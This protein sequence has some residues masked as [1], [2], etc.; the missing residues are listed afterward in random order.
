MRELS[1]DEQQQLQES[2]LSCL[3]SE[4]AVIKVSAPAVRDYLQGQITQ[5]TA[6]LTD[7]RG[8]YAAVLTPQGKAVSDIHLIQGH[9][10][11]LIIIARKAKAV[12]LVGRLRQFSL[13]HELRCGIVGALQLVSVQGAGAESFL[14]AGGLPVPG[15]E[16][17]ATVAVEGRECF[18]MRMAE[19]AA[20]GFWVVTDTANELPG[21][22]RVDES[23]IVTSRIIKGIPAFGIDWNEQVLPLNANLI[24]FDGV[25][26]NKGCYIGQEVTS[27]MQWRGGIKKHLYR[28]MLQS[29]P[30]DLPAPLSTTVPVGTL[31][32]AAIAADGSVYGI[33]HLPIEVAEG[34]AALHDSEGQPVRI[35]EVCHA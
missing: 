1:R 27:R 24:E 20:D 18:V 3:R 35:I 19:A 33:A 22:H 30:A 23:V 9:A 34:D 25:S 2:Y 12:D 5:D 17:L 32:S 13:G 4:Y 10:S 21:D 28:V 15:N 16:P 31:T 14:A 26:F 29:P 7:S 11:E 8:I 6:L